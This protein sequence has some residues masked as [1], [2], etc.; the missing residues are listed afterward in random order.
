M[1]LTS[2]GPT[3]RASVVV[4]LPADARLFADGRQLNLTGAERK[5]VSPDLPTDQEFVYRFRAEYERD[6]ETGGTPR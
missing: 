5:F 3:A 2:N 6:G 1:T 4:K